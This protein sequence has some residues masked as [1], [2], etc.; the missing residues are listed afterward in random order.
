MKKTLLTTAILATTLVSSSAAFA[1]EV[2]PA[3]TTVHWVG[4]ITDVI[5]GDNIVITGAGRNVNIA[6]GDLNLQTNGTFESSEIVLETHDYDSTNQTIGA[7]T[8]EATWTL[9]SVDYVWGS[10]NVANAEVQVFDKASTTPDEPLVPEMPILSTSTMSLQV[11]NEQLAEI[12]DIE[13]TSASAKV[14]VTMTAA[15]PA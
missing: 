14:N 11:K 7:N 8:V 3:Q 5:P 10:N 1:E 6:N 2:T 13:D 4:S 12:G 9:L 15:F